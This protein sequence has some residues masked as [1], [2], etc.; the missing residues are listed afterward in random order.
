MIYLIVPC[1]TFQ[2]SYTQLNLDRKGFCLCA[3]PIFG[4]NGLVN[5]KKKAATEL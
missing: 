1:A 5:N 2:V 4:L 3:L